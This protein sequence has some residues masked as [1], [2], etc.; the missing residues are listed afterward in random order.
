MISAGI[1]THCSTDVIHR[2]LLRC[3]TYEAKFF[4]GEVSHYVLS[5]S[6]NVQDSGQVILKL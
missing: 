3:N 1:L 4:N 5:L 6:L 2:H